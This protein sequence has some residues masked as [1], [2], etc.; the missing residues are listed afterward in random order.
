MCFEGSKGMDQRVAVLTELSRGRGVASTAGLALESVLLL[1][2]AM[3]HGVLDAGRAP[4]DEVEDRAAILLG[5][6]SLFVGFV[7][8]GQEADQDAIPGEAQYL[9]ATRRSATRYRLETGQADPRSRRP[10]V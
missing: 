1:L 5:R 10:F 2:A 8:G 9:L 3:A 6:R 7:Y 4:G